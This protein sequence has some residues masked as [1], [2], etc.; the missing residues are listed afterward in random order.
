MTKK[1]ILEYCIQKDNID[2]VNE[3]DIRV[4][5]SQKSF[6]YI[7]MIY[8][9]YSKLEHLQKTGEVLNHDS[10]MI[11]IDKPKTM[12][13]LFDSIAMVNLHKSN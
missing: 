5:Y 6:E 9:H 4:M 1:E 8:A 11:Q 7:L 10:H 12:E 2:G 13:E 3:D